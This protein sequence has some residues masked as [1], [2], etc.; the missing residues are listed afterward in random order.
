MYQ[1]VQQPDYMSMYQNQNKMYQNP[2]EL[3]NQFFN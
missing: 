3:Q 1:G 2:L